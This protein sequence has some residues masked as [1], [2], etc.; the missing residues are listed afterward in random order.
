MGPYKQ[1]QTRGASGELA[2]KHRTVESSQKS[3]APRSCSDHSLVLL[4]RVWRRSWFRCPKS[5]AYTATSSYTTSQT[6]R[7]C[8]DGRRLMTARKETGQPSLVAVSGLD[9]LGRCG[10]CTGVPKMPGSRTNLC[11]PRCGLNLRRC[12]L[13]AEQAGVLDDP[14]QDFGPMQTSIDVG[15]ILPQIGRTGPN[16]VADAGRKMVPNLLGHTWSYI[17]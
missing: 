16:F 15:R 6:V 14:R 5:A 13:T 11:F 8:T 4:L 12:P 1:V 3:G 2:H 7:G 17:D 10:Q 9:V